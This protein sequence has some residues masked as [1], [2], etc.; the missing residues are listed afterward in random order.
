MDLK[1]KLEEVKDRLDKTGDLTSADNRFVEINYERITGREFIRRGCGQCYKDAF[2]EMYIFY[3][4]NGIKKMG[5]F[6][7]KRGVLFHYKNNPYTRVNLTDEIAIERL[8]EYPN[9]IEQ[10]ESYPDNWQELI[11]GKQALKGKRDGRKKSE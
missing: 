4:K 11:T 9:T 8:K 6:I 5:E 1:T 10:Y 2:I 7:L 3:K